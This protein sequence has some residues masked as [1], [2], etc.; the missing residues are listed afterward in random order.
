MIKKKISSNRVTLRK[1]IHRKKAILLFIFKYDDQII[2]F[3]RSKNMFLWSNT[4]KSWYCQFTDENLNKVKKDIVPSLRFTFDKESFDTDK[5][6]Y[7][8]N[9]KL[10]EKNKI[11]IEG[12]EKYLFGKR[13]S[14]NTIKVYVG[15]LAD[16]IDYVQPKNI[17]NLENRDV[18]QFLEAIFV[19]RKYSISSQRQFISSIKLFAVYFPECQIKGLEL[20]RPYK[21]KKLPT[22][23]SQE[24]IIL[25]LQ[26]TLNLKHRAIIGLLYSSG[27]RIG[28]LLDLEIK[29]IDINRKQ[30]HVCNSKGRKDRYVTIADSF[31]PLAI[32]YVKS[33][34][35]KKYFVEGN[36]EY[37]KYS[38][39]SVRAF[40]RRSANLAGISKKVTPHTLRHSYATHLLEDGIDLRLIQ[41]LLGHSR[42][43]TTMIYTHVSKK[44]L[45]SVRSPLD[46][47]ITKYQKEN[48]NDL[49]KLQ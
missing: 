36:K 8:K 47:A 23:L 14:E 18:E 45:M 29:H 27:L 38:A 15:F 32:N 20:V 9:R 41:E 4:F 35:P 2:E 48:E 10:T 6:K 33:Y 5:L 30:L 39:S 22:V 13:Y 42:P 37:K 28:E 49:K 16:F 12:F 17:S 40:I 3:L 34:K 1:V 25:L 26:N 44:S 19:P 21:S 24:E 31:I 46:V 7:F 11:L 43:E